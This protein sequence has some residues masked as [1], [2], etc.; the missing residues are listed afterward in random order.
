MNATLTRPDASV[1]HPARQDRSRRPAPCAP[2]PRPP[3][4]RLPR[5]P[6]ARGLR[7]TR[8]GR[9]VVVL[10]SLLLLVVGFGLGRASSSSAADNTPPVTTVVQPGDTLWSIAGR[11]DP[12][13]DPRITVERLRAVN[14]LSS[15][16]L[17]AGQ[18]LTL[19]R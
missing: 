6:V 17:Q 18:L 8:R 2:A 13:Q 12:Q 3:V 16:G 10:I 9:I 1:I 7:L 15:A 14:H 11:I 5:S 19:P 4:A